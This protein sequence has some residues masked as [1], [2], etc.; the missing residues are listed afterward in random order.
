MIKSFLQGGC[1]TD[2]SFRFLVTSSFPLRILSYITVLRNIDV[3]F[4]TWG[5][6]RIPGG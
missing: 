2:V 3:Q 1:T 5:A 4:D 6:L